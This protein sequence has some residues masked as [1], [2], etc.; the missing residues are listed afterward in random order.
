M[1]DAGL[2]AAPPDYTGGDN[3]A[4]APS[5]VLTINANGGAS[6]TRRTR[7]GIDDPE[8][9]ARQKLLD[10]TNALGDIETAAGAAEP[11]P[12]EPFV[13]T[14]YRLQASG[15]PHRAT[16]QDPAPT[17]VDWPATQAYRWPRDRCARVDAAAVGSLFI[18]AKQNTYFKD[19]D[20]VYQVSVAG[21]CRAIPPADSSVLPS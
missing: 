21:S 4:D 3:V 2:L 6:C 11:R 8:S 5:T 14:A 19:G 1:Q 20:I 17:V 18:D 7:S 15:R 10:V 9:P 12:D 13:P 16:R